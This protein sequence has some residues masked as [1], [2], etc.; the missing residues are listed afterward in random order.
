MKVR[1]SAQAWSDHY[2]RLY[3]ATRV[4]VEDHYETVFP[5]LHNDDLWN[6]EHG[7]PASGKEI[8]SIKDGKRLVTVVMTEAA[9]TEMLSDFDFY[10]DMYANGEYEEMGSVVR[11]MRGAATSVR[12]QIAKGN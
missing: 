1:L 6:L 7:K 4:K 8:H 11:A 3:G 2:D 10:S 5:V 9:V 12:K